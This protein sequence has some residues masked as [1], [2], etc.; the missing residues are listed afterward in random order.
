M[1][2]SFSITQSPLSKNLWLYPN[3]N[4]HSGCTAVGEANNYECV[5][6]EYDVPDNDTTYVWAN[7]ESSVTDMYEIENHGSITGAINYVKIYARA[8]SH[9]YSMAG[10]GFY[11]ILAYHS[12]TTARSDAF[13]LIN[14]YNVYSFLLLSTPSSGAWNWT[15]IDNLRIGFDL[16]SPT[17][18]GTPTNLTLRPN[19]VGTLTELADYPVAGDNVWDVAEVAQDGDTTYVY[20]NDGHVYV[21]QTDLYGCE[22]HTTQ[23]GTIN[24]VSIFNWSKDAS[25]YGV[26]LL[27]CPCL[28]VYGAAPSTKNYYTLTTTYTNYSNTWTSQPSGTAW[29]WDAIDKMHIGTQLR[30]GS[31]GAGGLPRTTQVYAVVNYLGPYNPE[32]R[33]TQCYAM[34]NYTPSTSTCYLSRPYSYTYNNNRQINKINTWAGERLVYDVRRASKTLIMTGFE[35]PRPDSVA[36]TTLNCVCAMKDNGTKIT[37][38]GIGDTLVDTDW[39]IQ[40][41][42][43][44]KNAEN[45]NIYDWTLTLERYEN[46]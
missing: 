26:N 29:S 7:R 6:E 8:K 4:Y 18:A 9:I 35:Y 12:G 38:S 27:V 43:Y 34:V 19:S 28:W 42:N 14:D 40:D 13:N 31:T 1:V 15:A 21:Y 2:V 24:S 5:D 46:V 10:T 3:S 30:T 20:N 33:T 22:D 23:T 44:N 11:R 45:P 41:F 37:L 36:T 39:I 16:S 25:A 17:V 32:I